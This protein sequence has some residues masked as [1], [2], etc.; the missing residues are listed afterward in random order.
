M[1]WDY[2][3]VEICYGNPEL[4][5][6][7]I[8][9]ICYTD[10]M[11]PTHWY[12]IN[13]TAFE[14]SSLLRSL[15]RMN[16]DLKQKSYKPQ[17]RMHFSEKIL[18]ANAKRELSYIMSLM[19]WQWIKLSTIPRPQRTPKKPKGAKTW[20]KPSIKTSRSPTTAK[21]ALVSK[22]KTFA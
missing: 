3:L 15:R 9:E 14:V 7:Q 17:I 18:K 20:T 12:P 5:E 10:K 21:T 16:K 4:N 2:G 22:A 6:Y 1:K 8:V 13:F 11:K 19:P